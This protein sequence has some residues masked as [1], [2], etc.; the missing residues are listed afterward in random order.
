MSKTKEQ[1]LASAE[2]IRTNTAPN[3]NTADLVGSTL[4]DMINK[5]SDDKDELQN[6]IDELSEGSSEAIS[7]VRSDLNSEVARAKAA[8]NAAAA[9]V[10]AEET[11]AK[12]AESTL[13]TSLTGVKSDMN[14]LS[15]VND[16]VKYAGLVGTDDD[17]NKYAANAVPESKRKLGLILTYLDADGTPVTYQFTGSNISQ[18]LTITTWQGIDDVPTAGSD[19]L[20]KSGGVEKALHEKQIYVS[21]W[22]EGAVI[23]D[24]IGNN[25]EYAICVIVSNI[26]RLYH[27]ENDTWVRVT[28]IS[29]KTIFVY[30]NTLYSKQGGSDQTY[31]FIKMEASNSVHTSNIDTLFKTI[32]DNSINIGCVAYDGVFLFQKTNRQWDFKNVVSLSSKRVGNKIKVKYASVTGLENT[33][34]GTIREYVG[35]TRVG[36]VIITEA[37]TLYE[38]TTI[39]DNSTLEVDIYAS[40]S[41]TSGT[42]MLKV[43][44]LFIEIDGGKF[45]TIESQLNKIEST[46]TRQLIIGSL[47]N[48]TVGITTVDL[49]SPLPSKQSELVCE[50]KAN[51]NGDFAIYGYAN[52]TYEE[53]IKITNTD[54]SNG[55]L[56]TIHPQKK[57]ETLN[58]RT[59]NTTCVIQYFRI[60]LSTTP[61]KHDGETWAFYGDSI[62]ALSNGDYDSPNLPNTW[63]GQLAGKL[64]LSHIHTR[65]VGGQTYTYNNGGYYSKAGE[66]NYLNRALYDAN[67]NVIQNWFSMPLTTEQKNN[68][69]AK[70]GFSIEDHYGAFCSWDRITAM[71]PS[72]IKDT[73]DYVIV[74]GGT[75]DFAA[76]EE[77][78]GDSSITNAKPQFSSQNTEDADW[79]A[80]DKY[81]G[82]DYNISTLGGAIASTIMKLRVWMPLAKIIVLTPINRQS[83]DYNIIE[84]THGVS[85]DDFDN[86]IKDICNYISTSAVG[87]LQC[88][89]TLFNASNKLS[90][91]IHP[92]VKGQILM[93]E[94]LSEQ[95]T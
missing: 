25:G 46:V 59:W 52:G 78:E 15:L 49:R 42:G 55:Y 31:P 87:M 74:M 85:I 7:S 40:S 19:N 63:C 28:D 93:S 92:N 9:A 68:I 4:K 75:N 23:D 14:T 45:A 44:G 20:V 69:E 3:S 48:Y 47:L 1:L 58:I 18:W 26:N 81:L 90:D 27:K 2:E 30:N 82:G 39:S 94:Y 35:T 76:A 89:I 56:F 32:A 61:T 79:I 33:Y 12:A 10:T 36:N 60:Y 64:G 37:N 66:S 73:I 6:N 95:F 5:S 34:V 24:S 84:N 72:S 91:G 43:D 8:E 22:I 86:Y 16:G 54:F 80:S 77:V 88:G 38:Y 41:E 17:T 50:L 71:F 83:Q 21:Y 62:T 29:E 65:G 51:Y 13:N 57:Y 70:Y 53:V 67:G 11:R